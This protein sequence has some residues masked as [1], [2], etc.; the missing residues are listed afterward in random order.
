M[1]SNEETGRTVTLPDKVA[2]RML[3]V[4]ERAQAATLLDTVRK[5][6]LGLA[7]GDEEL[8]WALR[9]KITK[10][11]IYDERGTPTH[12]NKIKLLKLREQRAGPGKLD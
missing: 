12:R 10:E 6:L 2:N 4:G 1:N 9:R 3:T 11:L 8:H 7:H 5:E